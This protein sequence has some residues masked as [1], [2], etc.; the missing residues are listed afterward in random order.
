MSSTAIV[1]GVYIP[2]SPVVVVGIRPKQI[3]SRTTHPGLGDSSSTT[4]KEKS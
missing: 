2:M 4:T 1:V 3:T